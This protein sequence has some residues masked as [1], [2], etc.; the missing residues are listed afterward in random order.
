MPTDSTPDDGGILATAVAVSVDE[1]GII[2]AALA[3]LSAMA[4]TDEVETANL[5]GLAHRFLAVLDAV[6]RSYAD[7]QFGSP[8]EA[9]AFIRDAGYADV[10]DVVGLLIRREDIPN[11]VDLVDLVDVLAVGIGR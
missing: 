10:S 9:R 11:V 5:L 7:I 4:E 3:S 1:A 6:G 8:E 2:V